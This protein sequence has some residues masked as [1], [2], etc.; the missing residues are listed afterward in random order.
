[1]ISIVKN[2]KVIIVASIIV[3]VLMA[4]VLLVVKGKKIG[5]DA[6]IKILSDGIDLQ[7]KDVL[8]TDVGDSGIKLEIKAD[9]AKYLRSEKLALF[10]NV[11]I[12]VI[13]KDGRNYV[14][15]GDNGRL[16]TDTKDMEITGNVSILSGQGEH[17]TMD[18][19][20]Y[21]HS[22]QRFYTDSEVLAETS[23]MRLRGTGMSLS[24]KEQDLSL[25]SKVKAR[26]NNGS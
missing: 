3:V 8:Y 1:M 5:G 11:N 16:N 25:L 22:A 23:K 4:A 9:T 12:K 21:E 20:K 17:M 6:H 14:M 18:N 15:T 24:L 13:L 2:K 7:V 19:L 26:I 10:E